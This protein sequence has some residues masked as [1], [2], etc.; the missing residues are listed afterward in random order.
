MPVI[1][2]KTVDEF[3]NR[4]QKVENCIVKFGAKWCGPCVAMDKIIETYSNSNITILIIDIDTNDD[5]NSYTQDELN[6]KFKSIPTVYQYK[7]RKFNKIN[8]NVTNFNE[9]IKS[10]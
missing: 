7:N 8:C 6:L 2:I 9:V 4:L 5:L 10:L 3:K 1:H